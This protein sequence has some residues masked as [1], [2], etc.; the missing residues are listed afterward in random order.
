MQKQ[1]SV[2]V[3]SKESFLL[4]NF[5]VDPIRGELVDTDKFEQI[6]PK[7]MSV[8][9]F[10]V[11]NQGEVV[12]PETL[13]S[14]VW[15]K[16]IYSPG[17]IRRCITVL[18]KTL[19]DEDKKI[20]VTH[21]K[22]GYSLEAN[23]SLPI[24]TNKLTESP[25]SNI[26]K[27]LLSATFIMLLIGT[28]IYQS[29]TKEHPSEITVLNVNEILPLTATEQF[30]YYARYSPDGH[31][32]AFLRAADNSATS[33]QNL[34]HIW[35]KELASDTEY[36][37]TT[38]PEK[39]NSFSW[40]LDSK[41]LLY[42]TREKETVNVFRLK[43]E[44]APPNAPLIKVLSRTDIERITAIHWGM[45][46][47][48]YYIAQIKGVATL[49]VNNL[50]NGEQR[51]L[52]SSDDDFHPYELSISYHGEK[53]AVL[54]FN[55]QVHSQVKVISLLPGS[56]HTPSSLVTLNS[57]RYFI[58]WHPNNDNILLSDGRHLFNLT[59]SG[60]VDKIGFENFT[61]VR[62]PQFSPDGKNIAL[63]LE[64]I[65]E[66]IWL[67]DIHQAKS[68]RLVVNSNTSDF[69]P[70]FSPSGQEFAFVSARKGYPQLYIHDLKTGNNRLVFA[71]PEQNLSVY[72]AVWHS[73][74]N[75]LASA[76]NEQVFIVDM[77]EETLGIEMITYAQGIPLQWYHHENSLLIS[78]Q[79]NKT[80]FLSQ[81]NLTQ[82]ELIPLREKEKNAG[83]LNHDNELLLISKSSIINSLSN[84]TVELKDT[85]YIQRSFSTNNGVYLQVANEDDISLYFFS[86]AQEI[87]SKVSALQKGDN[88]STISQQTQKMLFTTRRIE[89]D[90]VILRL[91]D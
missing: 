56:D 80:R 12:D 16:S 88:I 82:K 87:L 90:I 34:W 49:F 63:T 78:S 31:Y 65:D 67:Q 57:N 37:L 39:I 2:A 70:R 69:Q 15:P 76:T 81:L 21:P 28:I 71:N 75:K 79:H 89:K 13:F 32:I 38:L 86:F 52:L 20:I 8:L 25:W 66:D 29:K 26:S 53:L 55:N 44:A 11:A 3:L 62:H 41:A 35:V 51:S 30:E 42:A 68:S 36:Q 59:A 23:I 18:R 43:N 9:I 4:N 46:N 45:D 74:G 10:L 60:Q 22:R 77:T 72:P 54:G 85:D 27:Y 5:T 91:D 50:T 33:H 24:K 1:N 14:H 40:S 6:E 73:D 84:S 19:N 17:S 7:V 58:S 83:Y 47:Q 61:F 48:L 64:N